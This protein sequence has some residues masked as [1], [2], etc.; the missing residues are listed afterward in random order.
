MF[1]TDK[2]LVFIEGLVVNTV[3]GIYEWERAIEQ[4]VKIDIVMFSDTKKVAD[5]HD[6]S[7]G[8]NYKAV[9]EAVESWTR[10]LQPELVEELAEYLANKLLTKYPIDKVSIKIGKPI[11]ISQ[12]DLVGVQIT[13]KK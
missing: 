4:P 12:A 5:S 7:T 6:L 8:V 9:S 10:D 11:A 13:R 2:D 1:A 3:L